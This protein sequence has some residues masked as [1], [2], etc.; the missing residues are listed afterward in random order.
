M[1]GELPFVTL[2]D[3]RNSSNGF[4]HILRHHGGGRGVVGLD[5][6]IKKK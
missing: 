6:V 5:D 2:I 3:K 4:V 1:K